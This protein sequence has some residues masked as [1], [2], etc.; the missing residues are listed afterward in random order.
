[1]A[2]YCVLYNPKSGNGKGI[3]NVHNLSKVLPDDNLRYVD[4]TTIEDLTAF[5]DSVDANERLVIA[6]GDGTINRFIN[7]VDPDELSKDIYYYG[8]GSGNDF[9]HDIGVSKGAAPI[10]INDY[11][12]NLPVLYVNGREFKFLNGIGFGIDGYCCEEADKI[13]R[14]SPG[15]KTNYTLLALKGLLGGYKP[16]NAEVI[17]DGVSYSFKKVWMVPT[18]N[19]R[20]FGG[21]FM[22]TPE[23]DRLNVNR[24]LSVESID[25]LGILRGLTL[26]LKVYKGTHVKYSKYVHIM[27]GHD[28]TV[29]FDRPCA[30]QVDGEVVF[31]VSEYHVV[32]KVPAVVM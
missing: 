17:V 20:Y 13:R 25:G 2:D 5:I 7:T 8:M 31:D 16:R 14:R 24:S 32:S 30:L 26:F 23:Q 27:E 28:I 11:I 4:I 6:G 15:K 21:G 1:M 12:K 10:L 19:G 9:Q 3:N 29:K 22:P 18:M